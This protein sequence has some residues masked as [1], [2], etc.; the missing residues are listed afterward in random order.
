LFSIKIKFILLFVAIIVSGRVI[1]CGKVAP[2]KNSLK[3]NA[4]EES[5]KAECYGNGS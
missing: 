3:K 2:N 1:K 4:G 5:E